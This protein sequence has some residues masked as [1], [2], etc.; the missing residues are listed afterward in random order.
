MQ[1]GNNESNLT[2]HLARKKDIIYRVLQGFTLGHLF[3]SKNGDAQI[4]SIEYKSNLNNECKHLIVL[5][6]DSPIASE[7]RHKKIGHARRGMT[8]NKILDICIINSGV[9]EFI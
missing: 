1:V 7:W 9:V 8:H 3:L 2:I 4:E 6:V 5:P